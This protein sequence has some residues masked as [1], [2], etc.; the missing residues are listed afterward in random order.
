MGTVS[1]ASGKGGA[2]KTS[3]A[4]ALAAFLGPS[5]VCADCDV[6]AA[7]GAIALG[8]TIREREPYFAGAAYRIEAEGCIGC[9]RCV[10]AC[11]FGAIEA[12]A[13][14]HR[15]HIVAELCERCGAC[16]DR[17]PTKAIGTYKKQAGELFVSSTRL[18]M[19]LVHA[20]LEPGE[21]TSGKLVRAVRERADKIA[22]AADSLATRAGSLVGASCPLVATAGVTIIADAPPG[23]GCP[24]IA[25]LAGTDLVLLVIEASASGTRDGARLIELLAT[26]KRPVIAILNKTGLDAEMDLRA[27]ELVASA[28]IELVGE[29]CFDPS[30]RSAEEGGTTWLSIRGPASVQVASALGKV[31]KILD[32]LRA[33]RRPTGKEVHKADHQGDE[34]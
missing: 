2:G 13:G 28:A 15:F 25:T 26:T 18:G 22:A 6:D 11:R 20:E 29:I 27:R 17:C 23:I 4:A 33:D 10:Q 30:L 12:D 34:I 8:A 21:D 14:G 7:N 9:G 16:S 32:S 31:V 5:C 3:I 1:V 19:T 24:V